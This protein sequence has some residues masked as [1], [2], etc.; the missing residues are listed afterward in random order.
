MKLKLYQVDA[1]A[2]QRF[3]GNPAA[4]C[5][6]NDWLPD[7]LM[8]SIAEEN[9]LSETAF[10]VVKDGVYH[11]RWFTPVHEVDLCG[12]ATLASAFVIFNSP[13]FT[14]SEINFESKSGRLRVQKKVEGLEMDFP[15]QVPVKCSAP[16]D[17]LNAF[18]VQPLECLKREDYILVFENEADVLNA[19]PD[20]SKLSK[21]DLRGVIITSVSNQYD[22][23]SRFFA[24]KY[25]INED[26]VTGSSFTQLAPYWAGKLDKQILSAKQ[27]SRRGGKVACINE[28]ERVKI[29][30]KAVLY[31]EAVIEV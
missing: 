14:E 18:D 30:G 10:F 8:Q 27:V 29:S 15:S 6:L 11:I 9:N 22:F 24:P 20:L 7:S 2:N 25:G 1:F 23:I 21:L 12:H 4:I 5:P 31:M 16:D 26:P 3:E 13:G 28:G 19:K 17:L